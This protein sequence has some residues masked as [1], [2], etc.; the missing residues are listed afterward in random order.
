MES[1]KITDAIK[2]E[3]FAKSIIDMKSPEEVKKSFATKDVEIS[4]D[5]AKMIISIIQK[6]VNNNSTELSDEYLQGIAGGTELNEVQ[7]VSLAMAAALGTTVADFPAN[8]AYQIL[9]SND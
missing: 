6:M 4:L 3:S 1:E 9:K 5:E 7:K 2:D 8:Q